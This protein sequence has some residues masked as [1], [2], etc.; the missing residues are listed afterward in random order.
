MGVSKI[1]SYGRKYK[2]Q[3]CSNLIKTMFFQVLKAHVSLL[4]LPVFRRGLTLLVF[5]RGLAQPVFRRGWLALLLTPVVLALPNCAVI[6]ADTNK[7]EL[8]ALTFKMA[9]DELRSRIVVMFDREPTVETH[10]LTRPHRLI[11]DLPEASFGF[12]KESLKPRGLI[13]DVRYGLIAEK[14]SRLILDAKG[15]FRVEKLEV[16]K[17]E[18]SAGYRMVVDIVAASDREFAAAIAEQKTTK[19]ALASEKNGDET[20]SPAIS[21]TLG[22]THQFTVMIDPGHGGIDSG[23]ESVSGTLEK[24]VTLAFGQELRDELMK[25]KAI[26][27][28]MTREDDTFLR[29]GERVRLARQ[30]E[31]DLFISLHA[32]T[33]RHK[34]IRGAT[35][36]TLSDK[37]SDDVAKAMAERENNSDASAGIYSEEAPVVHDILMELTQ[38]ETHSFSLN[39]A[40][41]LVGSLQ[42][43]VNLINNPHRFA[44]FQVLKAPDVPSVLVEIGYLSNKD[45]EKLLKDVAWRKRA[46]ERIAH[47]VAKYYSLRTDVETKP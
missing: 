2:S 12:D 8:A 30:H 23:A 28:L 16:L 41:G 45:D 40:N 43:E 17:N 24:N 31:A 27:V 25:N 39:F 14:R 11:I 46:V 37:A 44:G 1:G 32:D 38:R 22:S 35:V 29:L 19:N 21:E 13:S 34:E 20:A 4:T 6:A 10:L 47:A 18:S 9:G 5:R 33:I 36:Y 42:G 15:P 26:N 3:V 7:T